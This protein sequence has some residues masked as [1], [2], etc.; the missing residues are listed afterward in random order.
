MWHE[1]EML[2]H[3]TL[4]LGS[5]LGSCGLVSICLLRPFSA[6]ALPMLVGKAISHSLGRCVAWRP[7][8]SKERLARV[9]EPFRSGHT[10]LPHQLSS[11]LL[12]LVVKSF[13]DPLTFKITTL[14]T[15]SS[16]THSY[17]ASQNCSTVHTQGAWGLW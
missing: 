8:P 4:D 9:S 11:V 2:G 16:M 13:H 7:W 15:D 14:P 1:P 17:S 5:V 12:E 3:V 6:F 10:M